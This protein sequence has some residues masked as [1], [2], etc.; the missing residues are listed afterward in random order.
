MTAL[1]SFATVWRRQP[2]TKSQAKQKPFEWRSSTS[3]TCARSLRR[4][5]P[6]LK[7]VCFRFL[8]QYPQFLEYMMSSVSSSGTY[9]SPPTFYDESNYYQQ[10]QHMQMSPMQLT[11][12]QGVQSSPSN[13]FYLNHYSI[14]QY[15]GL[16]DHWDKNNSLFSVMRS[17]P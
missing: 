6:S 17:T 7:M 12:P 11:P 16:F 8:V 3:N 4:I 15:Q 2:L 1:T 13:D 14:P 5:F 9:P 10:Q